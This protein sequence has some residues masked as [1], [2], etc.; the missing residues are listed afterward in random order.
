[1]AKRQRTKYLNTVCS[2]W[3]LL[4]Q[5]TKGGGRIYFRQQ[6]TVSILAGLLVYISFSSFFTLC[7]HYPEMIL[8]T[9]NIA[10]LFLSDSKLSFHETSGIGSLRHKPPN[11][12]DSWI[13]FLI[14]QLIAA[15]LKWQLLFRKINEINISGRVI[16][17]GDY[18]V[19]F[20][21]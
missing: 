21:F 5:L 4:S 19:Q 20:K 7:I 16:N 15:H 6:E 1:M 9:Q 8:E 17:T 13:C 2:T 3:C 11:I 14:L 18:A 10:C 12:T